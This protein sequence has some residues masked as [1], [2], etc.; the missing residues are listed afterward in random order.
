MNCSL[1]PELPKYKDMKQTV[2]S[3]VFIADSY[4]NLSD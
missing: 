1:I 4:V 3:C 2:E